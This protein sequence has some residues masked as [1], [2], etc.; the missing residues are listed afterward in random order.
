MHFHNVVSSIFKFIMCEG[1]LTLINLKI[2][3]VLRKISK[4]S[5]F[6]LPI[7][8]KAKSPG[9]FSEY[10]MFFKMCKGL[11]FQSKKDNRIYL[12]GL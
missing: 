6:W 9:L 7:L 5:A 1:H 12:F 8:D 10:I 4:I 2:L 11:I 3:N